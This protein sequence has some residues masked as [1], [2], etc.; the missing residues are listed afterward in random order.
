MANIRIKD[1]PTEA[2]PASTDLIP[3]DQSTTR[4]ATLATV[5]DTIRPFADQT[6]AEAGTNTTDAMNPLRTAQAI[7][8]L[9]AT[10]FASAAQGTTADTALQPADI[11]SS[12]QGY[13][14]LLNS[15]SGL[16]IASQDII[17][18][19]GSNT[20]AKLGKGTDGQVLAVASGNVTW[21]DPNFAP[22]DNSVTNAKLTANS[23]SSDK[24]TPATIAKDEGFDDIP[25]V[26]ADTGLTYTTGQSGT[27][28]VGD[29]IKTKDGHRLQVVD[30][31]EPIYN[32]SSNT[33][34]YHLAN[35]NGTPVKYHVLPSPDGIYSADAF[36]VTKDDTD[37]TTQFRMAFEFAGHNLSL[38]KNGTIRVAGDFVRNGDVR[39]H[40]PNGVKINAVSGTYTSGYIFHAYGTAAQIEDLSASPSRG[41]VSLTAASTSSFA[42]GDI[43]TIYNPTNSS[44]SAFRTT[45]RAGEFI[46]IDS[47]SGTALTLRNSLYDGYTFGDVDVYQI[48][49]ITGFIDDIV[50][51]T[52]GSMTGVIK[53]EYAKGFAIRN[54]N[55]VHSNNSAIVWDRCYQCTTENPNIVNV[56]DGGDDYGIS[57]ANSQHIRTIGGYIY[58]RRH[59]ITIGG[60]DV[61]NAVS[62]RDIITF[63]TVLK[64]DRA[65]GVHCADFHGNTEDSYYINCTIYGGCTWQGKDVGY[66]GCSFYGGITAGPI[67]LAAEILGGNFVFENNSRVELFINPQSTGRGIIDVGGQGNAITS[68]T[69]EDVTFRVT[70]NTFRSSAFNASTDIVLIKNRGASINI[71]ADVRGNNLD[72]NNFG[73]VLRVDLVS[74]TAASDFLIADENITAL[75]GKYSVFPDGDY[76][77]LSVLRCQA[78][79]WSE[80]VT[81]DTGASVKAGTSETFKWR[82]PRDPVIMTAR[83][84]L[85]YAGNRIGICYANPIAGNAATL[86]IGT[87]DAT[88][89]ASAS[90]VVLS[91]EAAIREV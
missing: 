38:G 58:A 19:S 21:A 1:L 42:L 70:G 23:V 39:I 37:A 11:G 26:V 52:D 34:G 31:A 88:N 24:K 61:V 46:E 81:L 82:F 86:N 28:A 32:K 68:D 85:S 12:V 22:A 83:N 7:A 14:D 91:G 65:S 5:F 48:S 90:N 8:A 54:P 60:G 53:I 77:D 27:V 74:G 55:I 2:T 41:D 71:N 79:R 3:L 50:V 25:A 47:V 57:I 49:P 6:E 29:V 40:N 30:S 45:Y 69:V 15:V 62:C 78:H 87:D 56:G 66:K 80:T 17:V 16:T 64:N 13:D 59:P 43:G 33:D 89:F 35:S 63:G 4:K 75:S 72:V 18:G 9:G 76:A 84:D 51:E 67:L 73:Q 20:V 10:Q 36:N 44:W